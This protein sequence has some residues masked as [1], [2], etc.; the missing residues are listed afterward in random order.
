MRPRSPFARSLAAVVVGVGFFLLTGWAAGRSHLLVDWRAFQQTDALVFLG[1]YAQLV[2]ATAVFFQ[3][4]TADRALDRQLEVD[5][6]AQKVRQAESLLDLLG[7]AANARSLYAQSMPALRAVVNAHGDLAA[8]ERAEAELLPAEQF[9]QKA[10]AA[11]VHVDALCLGQDELTDA[12]KKITAA[13]D[14]QRKRARA[15]NVWS[16]NPT[17]ASSP[18]PDPQAAARFPM[19][20]HNAL[21]SAAS[22]LLLRPTAKN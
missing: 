16:R 18:A 3:I 15:V 6:H 4:R 5:V 8:V 14:E 2:L 12:A 21:L 13:L 20:A 10:H 7:A 19:D 9:R 17:A 1:A 22:A 11:R